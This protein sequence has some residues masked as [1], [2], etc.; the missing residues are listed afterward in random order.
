MLFGNVNFTFSYVSPDDH[1]NWK[2]AV[3]TANFIFKYLIRKHK[4]T[5]IDKYSIFKYTEQ[6]TVAFPSFPLLSS[7]FK[8][9]I[10]Y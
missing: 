7:M 5:F 4:N 9:F 8:I 3:A 2:L 6:F 10:E 1:K